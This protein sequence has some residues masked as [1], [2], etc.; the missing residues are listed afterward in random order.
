MVYFI[1]NNVFRYFYDFYIHKTLKYT[2][3]NVIFDKWI[4][5]VLTWPLQ[6]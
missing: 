4:E 5:N 1:V 3:I 6:F 2:K